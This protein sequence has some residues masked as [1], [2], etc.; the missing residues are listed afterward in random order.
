MAVRR[1]IRRLPVRLAT[2]P[3]AARRSETAF[4]LQ[5]LPIFGGNLQMD[6]PDF[7]QAENITIGLRPVFFESRLEAAFD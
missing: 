7:R 1:E 2:G 5:S 4:R 3:I 6:I